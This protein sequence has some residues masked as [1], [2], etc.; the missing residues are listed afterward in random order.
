MSWSND[1]CASLAAKAAAHEC[2]SRKPIVNPET[3]VYADSRRLEQMLTNLID[4][5]IK[6]SREGGT[7]TVRHESGTRDGSSSRTMATGFRRSI[8]NGSSSVFT[9]STA[10][11]RATWAARA[12]PRDRE[13]PG[14]PPRRRGDRHI[15]SSEK[16]RLLPSTCQ[17]TEKIAL[18]FAPPGTV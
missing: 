14:A 8:W 3:L 15:L 4:N 10:P 11:G 13:A 16:A 12:G 7:V 9:G 1:V 2:H 18:F 5:G 17:N 6:F